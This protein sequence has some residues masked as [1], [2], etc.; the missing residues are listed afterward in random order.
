M[1]WMMIL[2]CVL[3]L[4][5]ILLLGSSAFA[6]GGKSFLPFITFLLLGI[7]LAMAFRRHKPSWHDDHANAAADFAKKQQGK[8]VPHATEEDHSCCH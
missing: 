3:P 6:L 2:C 1:M 4:V 5:A 7:C 8:S